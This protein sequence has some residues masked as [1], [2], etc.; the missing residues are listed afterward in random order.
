MRALKFD[1]YKSDIIYNIKDFK[2]YIKK[3]SEINSK[4]YKFYE[5]Y[6]FRKLKLNSYINKKKHE[7]VTD[8]DVLKIISKLIKS[9]V[10]MLKAIHAD[11]SKSEYLQILKSYLP[12]MMSEKE[13]EAWVL[14]NID[15]D[16][17]IIPMKAMGPIMKELKGKADGN[18]VKQ[19]LTRGN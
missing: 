16:A 12:T 8:E 19:V 13:I 2:E 17:Y 18:L 9:E 14:D 10:E 6:I 3:K 7:Q 5:K 11:E 4:L 15:F 1:E